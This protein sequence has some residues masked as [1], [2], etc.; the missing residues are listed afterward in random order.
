MSKPNMRWVFEKRRDRLYEA[1]NHALQLVQLLKADNQWREANRYLE[2][3]IDNVSVYT[4]R[5]L[6]RQIYA[7]IEALISAQMAYEAK[8]E[9]EKEQEEE[10]ED[11]V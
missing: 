6:L 5:L 3:G 9:A 11:E 1:E 8:V 4:A 2:G 7:E 10:E